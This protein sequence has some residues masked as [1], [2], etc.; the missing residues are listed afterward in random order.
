[1][2]TVTEVNYVDCELEALI[3]IKPIDGRQREAIEYAIRVIAARNDFENHKRN[4]FK[5]WELNQECRELESLERMAGYA[6][7]AYRHSVNCFPYTYDEDH[8]PFECEGY[9]P[10]LHYEGIK[11]AESALYNAARKQEESLWHD[12]MNIWVNN[13]H[14]MGWDDLWKTAKGIEYTAIKE[15]TS[16]WSKLMG[17]P[18]YWTNWQ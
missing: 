3:N 8:R 1:M 10:D 14:S 15:S 2:N 4:G 13:A 6:M 18:G 11:L 5:Q 7:N 16:A 9:N 17:F 12:L